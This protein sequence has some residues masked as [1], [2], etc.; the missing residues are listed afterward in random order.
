MN[1]NEINILARKLN[2]KSFLGVFAADQL[3]NIQGYKTGVLICNT[4]PSYLL[5]EHWIGICLNKTGVIFYDS[6]NGDFYKSSFIKNFLKKRKRKLLHNEIQ[7]QTNTSE[8]CGLH[9]LVFCYVLSRNNNE[10][11]FKRFLQTFIPYKLPER[12]SLSLKYFLSFV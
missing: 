4:K 7:I 11:T 6:L 5:G 10:R 2:I 1:S 3:V 8:R 9:S 12:E